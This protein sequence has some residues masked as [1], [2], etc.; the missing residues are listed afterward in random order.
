MSHISPER[1]SESKHTCSATSGSV[2]LLCNSQR[3]LTSLWE[4]EGKRS[5]VKIKTKGIGMKRNE[6]DIYIYIFFLS[7]Q[8]KGDSHG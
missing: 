1:K 2:L 7:H 4:A 5:N 8:I 6:K 3:P